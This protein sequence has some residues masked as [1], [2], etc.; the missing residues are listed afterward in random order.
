MEQNLEFERE[1]WRADLELRQRELALKERDQA[2]RDADIEIRRRDQAISKWRSP[3]VVAVF[4]AAAAAL[5]NAGVTLV[6]GALQ[7]DLESRKQ[8]AELRVEETKAESGRLLEMIK[9]DSMEAAAKNL[10]FLLDTGLV[11]DEKRA[12]KIREFVATR[13][14]PVLPTGS[15]RVTFEPSEVF[16]KPVQDRLEKSINEFSGYL[17]KIGFPTNPDRVKIINNQ[18]NKTNTFYNPSTN[19]LAIGEMILDDVG[20]A[21]ITYSHHWLKLHPDSPP[22]RDDMH[23][24]NAIEHGLADYFAASFLNNPRV[25]EAMARVEKLN[26]PYVRHLVNERRFGE[27]RN[28]AKE[29]ILYEGAEIWGGAF[30]EMRTQITREV[31]DPILAEA[32]MSKK[33]ITAS[34]NYPAAFLAELLAVSKNKIAPEKQ[35]TIRELLRKRQFPIKQ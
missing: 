18:Y 15:S 29:N 1:K 12:A 2:N 22:D 33:W 24:R 17:A 28:I 34:S 13:G 23:S 21:L 26:T 20:A 6:N 4:A 27:L 7:R 25:G 14:A 35:A 10:T 16:T 30:W 19:E 11:T 5:G 31:M 3:L 32:W 9:T 8:E